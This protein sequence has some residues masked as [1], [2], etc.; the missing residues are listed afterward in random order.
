MLQ[1][2]QTLVESG[3]QG[4][5]QGATRVLQITKCLQ[6]LAEVEVQGVTNRM[7]VGRKQVAGFE[8]QVAVSAPVLCVLFAEV[9]RVCSGGNRPE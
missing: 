3:F 2:L 5:T 7:K 9:V 1:L 8:L 4:V 6:T